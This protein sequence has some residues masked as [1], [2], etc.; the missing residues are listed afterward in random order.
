MFAQLPHFP[1]IVSRLV[2]AK[3]KT[4]LHC[5]MASTLPRSPILEAM[6]SHDPTSTAVIHAVSGRRFTYGELV[7]DVAKAKEKL[8]ASAGDAPVAGQRIAFLVEN[9]YDYVGANISWILHKIKLT[10]PHLVTL[11]SVLSSNSIAVPLSS[12]FPLSELRYILENSEAL[13]LLTSAKFRSKADDVIKEGLQKSP[14]LSQVE[15]HIGGNTAGYKAQLQD[16]KNDLAGMMLYTSGTT[17]RPVR[18]VLTLYICY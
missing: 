1:F 11:L 14:T 6:I 8:L 5:R 13:M 7:H 18:S 9:G 16:L 4:Q 15:K 10:N 3:L 2:K 12:G 17:S